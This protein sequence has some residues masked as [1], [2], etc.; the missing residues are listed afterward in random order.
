MP[1]YTRITT[2]WSGA[3]GLPGYTGFNF[4]G[5]LTA[6]EAAAAAARVRVFWDAIRTYVPLG[7]SLTIRP[8]ATLYDDNLI[9]AGEVGFAAPDP[10]LGSYNLTYPSG[11]GVAINWLTDLYIYGRRARGRTFL[12]PLPSFQTDGTISS[13]VLTALNT[14]CAALVGGAPK[15]VIT[16]KRLD[17]AGGGSTWYIGDITAFNIADRPAFLSSRRG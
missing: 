1:G 4:R 15:L 14:A 7:V 2:E 16:G 10:V 11:V 6:E 5:Q 8:T 17:P 9:L 3:Q 13:A 12:V